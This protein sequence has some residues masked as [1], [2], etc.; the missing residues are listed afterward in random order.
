[1]SEDLKACPFCGRKVDETIEN[2][3]V[4]SCSYH[5]LFIKSENWNTRP[6]EDALRAE[7]ERLRIALY[8]YAE[9]LMT[10]DGGRTAREALKGGDK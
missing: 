1:M 7:N 8:M 3:D 5:T 2:L 6:I 4:V 10:Q 9:K